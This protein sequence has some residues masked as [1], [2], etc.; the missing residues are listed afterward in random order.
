MHDPGAIGHWPTA[1][2]PSYQG[3]L[4]CRIPCQC[5]E[6]PSSGPVI[7]LQTFTVIVSPQLAS[8]IGPGNDPLIRIELLL[9]PSG[10]MKPRAMLKLYVGPWRPVGIVNAQSL[11]PGM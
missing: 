2:T 7:W 9:T 3:V 8:I 4:F 6:V 5:I 1:G 10:E 11:G